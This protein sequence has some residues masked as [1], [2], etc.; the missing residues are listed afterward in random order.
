M[1]DH[2]DSV[3]TMPAAARRPKSLEPQGPPV[4]NPL[5]WALIIGVVPAALFML[6][7]TLSSFIPEVALPIVEAVVTALKAAYVP[8]GDAFSSTLVAAV[9]FKCVAV[10]YIVKSMA[11]NDVYLTGVFS[12]VIWFFLTACLVLGVNSH[13]EVEAPLMVYAFY[14]PS[15]V[16]WWVG[17]SSLTFIL[18][19]ACLNLARRLEP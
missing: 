5:L 3:A 17:F 7:K 12:G 19:A 8:D 15:A 4:P 18:M 9:F 11:T 1:E 6:Y 13:P 10:Y 16:M 2:T 14:L